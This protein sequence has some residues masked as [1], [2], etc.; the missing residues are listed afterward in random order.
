MFLFIMI[1]NFLILFLMVFMSVAFFTLLERKVLG[2]IQLR[3]GPNKFLMKGVFQPM[4]DGLKLFFKEVNYPNNMNFF[5]F[6]ISPL[7]GLLI[8]IFF[9]FIYPFIGMN[10]IMGFGLIYMFCCSSLMVYIFL[11]ISWSSNS[12]YSVLGMIRFI[13]QMISYEVSM[14][15]IIMNLMFLINSFNLNDFYIY[16]I[17]LK[18]FFFLFF[19]FILLLISFLAEMNRSPFDFSEGESELVSGFNIEF[20]SLSFIFIF[21]SEYMSIMFMGMLLCEMFFGMMMNKFYLNIFILIFMFMVI[22]LRGFLPRFR[23]DKLMYLIWKL[24]LP[25]SLFLFMFNFSIKLF[26][27]YH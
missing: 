12:N 1:I 15:I 11:L 7:L 17:N 24:V 20:S 22:W 10:Y 18:F 5:Y 4:G 9:W 14:M 16:Q 2:Y 27:L 8:S 6:M 13:S 23:Y 21:M 19:L 26:N 3:K 25:L